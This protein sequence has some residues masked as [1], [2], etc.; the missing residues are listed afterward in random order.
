MNRVSLPSRRLSVTS[1]LTHV[2]AADGQLHVIATFGLDDRHQVRELFCSSFKDG[3][4]VRALV[5]DA[6]VCLSLL[7]QHGYSVRELRDKLAPAPS[8]LL[9]TLIDEAIKVEEGK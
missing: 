8:S 4:D 7:L 2:T 6:C 3:V 9:A 1:K 5:M